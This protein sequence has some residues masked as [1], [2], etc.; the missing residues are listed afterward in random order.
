MLS[1]ESLKQID[2][3]LAKYPADQRRSAIMGALSEYVQIL[4]TQ[5]EML[6]VFDARTRLLH[7]LRDHMQGERKN[8]ALYPLD[9][10][11]KDLAEYLAIRAETLSRLLKQLEQEAVLTWDQRGVTVHDWAKL[12]DA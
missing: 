11:K 3:E 7:Y 2:I 4:S 9:I 1:A 5:I 8:G 10:N 12:K 6:S